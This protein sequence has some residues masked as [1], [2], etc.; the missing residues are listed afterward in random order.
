MISSVRTTPLNS[1]ITNLN[2]KLRR[3]KLVIVEKNSI[4]KLEID[5]TNF[6]KSKFDWLAMGNIGKLSR[7]LLTFFKYFLNIGTNDY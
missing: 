5:G 4:L 3:I 7:M 2:M 6:D 1:Q